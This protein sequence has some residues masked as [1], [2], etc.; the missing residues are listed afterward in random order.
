MRPFLTFQANLN[1]MFHSWKSPDRYF[2]PGEKAVWRNWIQWRNIDELWLELPGPAEWW[3]DIKVEDL[4]ELG[5]DFS[6]VLGDY[7]GAWSMV[8]A[9]EK[10]VDGSY[11]RLLPT[12]HELVVL[13]PSPEN[14]AFVQAFEDLTFRH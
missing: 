5:F 9:V 8:W 10:P 7:K 12:G 14:R 6:G 11:E 2:T 1:R 4:T 3:D 13:P